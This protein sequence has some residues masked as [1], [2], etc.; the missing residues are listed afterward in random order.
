MFQEKLENLEE[1]KTNPNCCK[2]CKNA[3]FVEGS[4]VP[5]LRALNFCS[6]GCA[7]KFILKGPGSIQSKGGKIMAIIQRQEALLKYYKA[8]NICKSCGEVILVR[9]EEKISLV[10]VRKFC[11][12]S[13]SASFNN[14]KFP[15][16][17]GIKSGPC[18]KCGDLI[19]Y[20]YN[21]KKRS[22]RKRSQC[23]KCSVIRK[24]KSK[25]I[26]SCLGCTTS[27]E[28]NNKRKK[29][30]GECLLRRRSEIAK[31]HNFCREDSQ[32]IRHKTKK[33]IKS[34]SKYWTQY[35]VRIQKHAKR[36]LEKSGRK[37]Q[38]AHCG[39]SLHVDTCHIKDVKDFPDTAT[40]SEI[41]SLDN[42]IYLCKNHHWEFDNGYLTK[43]QILT[44]D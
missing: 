9:G 41:N 42:L 34:Q 44:K 23:D 29:Y 24:E 8:P 1:Y 39:Y 13:C 38:C 5:H 22:Y 6:K 7:S 2:E 12:R 26:I 16:R 28:T 37:K 35:R 19:L 40:V 43:D 36:T 30:C 14:S 25:S 15:K 3:I 21:S 11:D 18:L 10:K 20:T 4:I 33:E 32:H 17:K 27:V 31:E